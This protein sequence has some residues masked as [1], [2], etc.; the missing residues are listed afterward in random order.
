[1]Q[2]DN[3]KS[4]NKHVAYQPFCL[5]TNAYIHNSQAI[6][7]SLG[8]DIVDFKI[9]KGNWENIDY[10]ILN[11]YDTLG[12]SWL[13]NWCIIGF[14]VLTLLKAKRKNVLII[15]TFHNKQP[16]D[17]KGVMQI[18]FWTRILCSLSDRIIILSK[19]S[20]EYLKEYCSNSQI[21]KKA[22]YIPHPNYI[23]TYED[24]EVEVAL[25]KKD[26][27]RLL[28]MGQIRRYKNVELIMEVAKHF[29]NEEIEFIIAG[30]PENEVY[31]EELLKEADNIKNLNM[32]LRFIPDEELSRMIV[33]ADA[34]L[35]PYD[36]S[37]S[38]NSGTVLLAFSYAKNVICPRIATIYDFDLDLTYSYDYQ[39]E[40]QHKE[41]LIKQINKAYHE[42]KIDYKLFCNKGR[43]LYEVVNIE[44]SPEKLKEYY[45]ELFS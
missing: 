31:K 30:K 17:V 6:I 36:I 37:S 35:L 27:L 26:R 8:Y 10:L 7:R 9:A 42:W 24:V 34:L 23:G 18:K 19:K 22:Y 1:M 11:W 38:M 5:E 32:Q 12:K 15:H 14:R 43:K 21:N 28:F 40:V 39:D 25:E 3:N 2:L 16:H 44:N 29:S 33:K 4:E 41:E 45:K 13:R 20:K